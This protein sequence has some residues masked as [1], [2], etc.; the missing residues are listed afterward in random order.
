MFNQGT[1]HILRRL[2]EMCIVDVTNIDD[3]K[4]LLSKKFAEVTALVVSLSALLKA[5]LDA[6]RRGKAS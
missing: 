3:E 6:V 1:V 4:Y 5:E 2:Y